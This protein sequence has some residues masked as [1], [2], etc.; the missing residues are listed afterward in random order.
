MSN[1]LATSFTAWSVTF[2]SRNGCMDT[3]G[4]TKERKAGKS[5]WDGHNKRTEGR[6]GQG[7]N[8]K[9]TRP[10]APPV[11]F[12]L[13]FRQLTQVV[14]LLSFDLLVVLEEEEDMLAR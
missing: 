6:T 5:D 8:N 9:H 3:L 14:A 7:Q 10:N 4:T 12:V 11:H 13:D 1:R 2:F